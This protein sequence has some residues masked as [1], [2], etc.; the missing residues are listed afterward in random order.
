[1]FRPPSST[2][3]YSNTI[4]RIPSS[5]R[6]YSNTMFGPPSSTRPSHKHHVQTTKQYKTITQTP[7][8]DHQAA[9]DH[10]TN[11]IFRPPSR[12]R[13]YTKINFRLNSTR[14]HTNIIFRPSRTRLY[15]NTIF[16]PLS[17]TRLYT[18]ISLRPGGKSERL[19]KHEPQSQTSEYNPLDS[20]K[21]SVQSVT[22]QYNS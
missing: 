17:S 14:L 9:Q 16:R 12:T 6:L 2:R 18:K 1:M 5:T 8:S 4:F 22:S 15:L 3:L 11:T 13:L 10:H 20:T 19:R 21:R 7:C